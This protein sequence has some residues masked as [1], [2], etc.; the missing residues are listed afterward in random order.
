MNETT[1]TLSPELE[2]KRKELAE[3]RKAYEAK[4]AENA[5]ESAPER[6]AEEIAADVEKELKKASKYAKKNE[7]KILE[8]FPLL[9]SSAFA[10]KARECIYWSEEHNSIA[11]V[12][13]DEDGNGRYTKVREKYEWDKESKPWK[14]TDKRVDGSKWIKTWGAPAYP[15][16]LSLFWSVFDFHKHYIIT[17]GEKDAINVNLCGVPAITMGSTSDAASWGKY[18]GKLPEGATPI[19]WF[20]NDEA[21]RKASA[22]VKAMFEAKG[23]TPLVVKW[24]LLDPKAKN[25]DDATDHI[26]KFGADGLHDRLI[27]A[28]GF[29]PKTREWKQ[30]TAE[31]LPKVRPLK[32]KNFDEVA[33]ALD[34]YATKIG[35]EK[36][37][38]FQIEA[39]ELFARLSAEELAAFEGYDDMSDEGKAATKERIEKKYQKQLQMKLVYDFFGR[40]AMVSFIK[41]SEADAVKEILEL[42]EENGIALFR[43]YKLFHYYSGTHFQAIEP[44]AYQNFILDFI[45]A[46]KVNPKQAYQKKF[47]LE[48]NGGV[49]ERIRHSVSTGIEDKGIINHQG[50]TIFIGADG[51]LEHRE[52]SPEDG[53]TYCLPFAYDPNAKCEM[54]LRFL[55]TS[56]V[57]VDETGKEIPDWESIAILQEYV[58]Y[59]FLPKYVDYF[60]YLY[61][62]GAN[63]KSVFLS[64]IE[65]LFDESSVA[66][67]NLVNMKDHQL[68]ALSGKLINIASEIPSGAYLTEQI[69]TLKSMVVGEPIP[70][71]PKNRDAYVLRRPP[72]MLMAGNE[73]LKGGGTDDGLR[74]R[75]ITI[76]FDK[77]IPVEKRIDNLHGKIIE[78]E[79]PGILN[80]VLEGLERFVKNNY[81]FTQSAKSE[82]A[83]RD[84]RRRTD[85]VWAFIE[86]NFVMGA[87]NKPLRNESNRIATGAL[88]SLYKTWADKEGVKALAQ[89]N[90]TT[91]LGMETHL[92]KKV[93]Q[94]SAKERYFVGFRIAEPEGTLPGESINEAYIKI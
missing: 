47:I 64:V 26:M 36:Y 12:C 34:K 9:S 94:L 60:I 77:Q 18:I 91:T 46:A 38:H 90:F 2:E 15:F 74:R 22:K 79:L 7:P 19:L 35:D 53:I 78:N 24:E 41:H 73:E 63:G 76:A 37:T 83:K 48:V 51:K 68:D 23:I 93:Q 14:L 52:H 31:L 39:A 61:G 49:M 1:E 29:V 67:L 66:R 10:D 20:D 45:D 84:Y 87:D 32:S 50:G 11:V 17:E 43:K 62:L 59:C 8:A 88:Y 71:N 4:A 81:K 42:F 33:I 16:A 92:N 28:C 82:E 58:A 55:S 3:K 72:K 57:T 30:I 6:T 13:R 70:I 86:D 85:H 80:W 44:E 56:L 21:G 75:I 40:S 25:K 5:K 69:A 89:K 27:K 54:W 65:A